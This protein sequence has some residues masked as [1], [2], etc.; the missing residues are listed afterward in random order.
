MSN[1]VSNL[2]ENSKE[3]KRELGLVAASALVVGNMIGS[4]I[5]MIPQSLAAV[6]NPRSTL[7]AWGVT[8]IGSIL[9]A[10]SFAKL[11]TALPVT[12]GPIVYTRE[13]FGDFAAFIVTWGYWLG[14]WIGDAAI[15]T[16][17]TSYFSY[18]FPSINENRFLAFSIS[19]SMLW[20]FTL[21]NYKGVKGAGVISI[22]TT[23][24]K[25]IPIAIF[26]VIASSHFDLSNYN[27]FSS[28][29]V[30]SNSTIPLAIGIT[31]WAFLG[32][33]SATVVSGEIK[34]PERNIRLSTILGI[35]ITAGIYILISALAIGVMP[36]EKLAATTS[37]MA[38][39]INF[40]TGGTWGGTLIAL[41]AIVATIG[42][43]SGWI[44]IS[45]RCAFA[46]AESKLFPSFFEKVHPK[47]KTP[48]VALIISSIGTN[49]VLITNYVSSLTSAFSFIILL[50]TMA[51]LPIYTFTAAADILLLSKKS[52]KFNFFSFFKNSFLS[53]V[54]FGYSVYAIYG[55][56]ANSVMFGFIL[57]L[58]GIPFYLYLKLQ[59]DD[60]KAIN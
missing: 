5:F 3:L 52:S 38:E 27:T 55:T 9:L 57:L 17:S 20:I 14:I 37:P 19:T 28:Q 56:G 35:T 33:E 7:I 15:I 13:A 12:G 24:F 10:L 39:I 40:M 26:V 50:S 58:L 18:F 49:L 54:A 4:G 23:V 21:I 42:T 59:N 2:G 30:N 51:I 22:I 34:N 44:M 29:S 31:L 1:L 25:I 45:G 8:A 41:G 60:R 36:Q 46:A 48:N 11:G 32:L 53:L 16:A 6:S 43:I 47:Y